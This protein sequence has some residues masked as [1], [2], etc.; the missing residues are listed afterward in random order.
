ME[1]AS[2]GRCPCDCVS[3][4]HRPRVRIL[5]LGSETKDCRRMSSLLLPARSK[6]SRATAFFQA[7]PQKYN[8]RPLFRQRCHAPAI[9]ALWHAAFDRCSAV[10]AVQARSGP[11]LSS[12][13]CPSFGP[14]ARSRAISGRRR[15]GGYASHWAP[16]SPFLVRFLRT[17]FQN[18]V[19]LGNTISPSDSSE[20]FAA[21]ARG[22]G[23]GRKGPEACFSPDE[24]RQR[25]ARRWGSFGARCKPRQRVD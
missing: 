20:C 18:S 16:G 19:S 25:T 9:A 5:S 11:R 7:P 22:D 21:Y 12:S 13:T 4:A 1:L 15:L 6:S 2:S 14:Q 17:L 3:A 10:P 8:V 23:S 24:H